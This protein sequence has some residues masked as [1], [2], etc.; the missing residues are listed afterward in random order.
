MP[1]QIT[2]IE[3]CTHKWN[4][5][6]G[7]YH[8][9]PYC[10]ARSIVRRF[11]GH[12]S[13]ELGVNTRPAVN[14][15]H[16]VYLDEH[17]GR[18]WVHHHE[19]VMRLIHDE[20]IMTKAG[21]LKKAPYPYGFIPT[22]HESRL[23]DPTKHKKTA[24]VFVGSMTDL[25]GAWVPDEWIAQVLKAC[26]AAPQHQYLFLTKNPERLPMSSYIYNDVFD[27]HP[28]NFWFGMSITNQAAL[29]AAYKRFMNIS[30]NTFLSIE[31]L[32]GP[33]DLTR[34]DAGDVF[35]DIAKGIASW[36]FGGQKV[37]SP[38]WIII[39]AETGNRKGKVVPER[40]RVEAICAAADA[41]GVPVFMKDSLIPIMGEEG[42]RRDRPA[43]LTL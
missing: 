37:R 24:T 2:S 9:C 29:N 4:P 18:G 22:F 32:H 1:L 15:G 23:G 35:Y 3:W 43:E 5:V 14:D 20:Q 6:T 30:G 16:M 13:E 41:G 10:Y 28:G 40:A 27:N 21:I 11:G 17:D 19:P 25:F 8:D 12:Y 33:I 31:P 7:C 36:L 42:M 39:G 34:I 38:G 26:Y